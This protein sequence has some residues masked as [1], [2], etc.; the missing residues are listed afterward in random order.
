MSHDEITQC[1]DKVLGYVRRCFPH[2]DDADRQDAV[3]TVFVQTIAKGADFVPSEGTLCTYLCKA[4]FYAALEISKKHERGWFQQMADGAAAEVIDSNVLP[5]L[6][7]QVR[8][9]EEQ[10]RIAA[11]VNRRGR[12]QL[13]LSDMLQEY[14]QRC[15]LNHWQTEREV[16]ERRLHGQDAKV[17]MA[18]MGI[19]RAN[20]DKKLQLARDWIKQRMRQADVDRSVFQTFLRPTRDV[21]QL[22]DS[23]PADVPRNFH[24]VLM[25][26]VNEFGAL[27]P[28]DERLA[29][30]EQQ[31]QAAEFRD[32]R[33]HIAELP[34]PVCQARRSLK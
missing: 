10:S 12:Q 11:E 19:T 32:L 16:Y 24:E 14:V 18:A 23:V 27:C 1:A 3:Q 33:Y 30:F 4:A 7:A 21:P 34:C 20:F 26:V 9:E 29:R 5:P 13:L 17:I 15:E 28:S 6:A 31:P 2:M 22:P 8:E 25:R